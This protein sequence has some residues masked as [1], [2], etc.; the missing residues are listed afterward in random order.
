MKILFIHTKY[1]QSAGGEDTTVAAESELM[2]LKGHDVRIQ[3]FDNAQM[4]TGISGKLKA[5]LDSVYN[6]ASAKEINALI[7]EF[8]PDIVHIHNFFFTASPSVISA[9]YKLRVPIV[10]T[11]QNYRLI[12]ANA[13]LL[14]NNNVCELC[15]KH[16]FPW[17]GV[18]YKCYHGSAVQSAMVGAMSAI[19]KWKGTWRNKVD[20]YITPAE[21]S[22]MKFIHSS[23]DVS[24][25]KIKVKRNFITDPGTGEVNDRKNYYLFI[26]RLS[27]EKGVNILLEAWSDLPGHELTIAG[28]GPE[29][30]NLVNRFG[31]LKNVTFV[32]KKQ[33][34]EVIEL[35]KNCRA[36]VFPS[37]WY[38][39]LPLTI[40]ESFA[41]GTPVIGSDL[42][43]MSEMIKD[44][45]NGIL[46]EPGNSVSL[47]KSIVRFDNLFEAGG[48]NMYLQARESYLKWYHPEKC[49]E[50]VMQ[51][52]NGVINSKPVINKQ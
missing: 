38:E 2:K 48:S 52:Y 7:R 15:V 9:A 31:H 25:E 4:R 51:L 29:R 30:E 13:L 46:F 49:Y 45:N 5:G 41:T 3:Y 27:S 47:K 14:R 34:V 35:M 37:I 50:A 40:I 24:P 43:A 32:G 8:E 42:G 23:L 6:T 19:H 1:L 20:L 28:D 21:F 39:G 12:C 16:H 22:R 11:L 33:K 44:G 10:V 18:K 17:Y 36:L 26:G